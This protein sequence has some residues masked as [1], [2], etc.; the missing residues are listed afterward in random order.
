MRQ[1]V[2]LDTGPIV[3]LIDC[4]DHH[5][6]WITTELTTIQP[7]LLCCEAVISEAWFLLQR[8]SNG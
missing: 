5:H 4:R 2:L 7:L 3:A 1:Q 6:L 8:V